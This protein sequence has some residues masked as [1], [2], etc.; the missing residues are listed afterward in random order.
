MIAITLGCDVFT[1]GIKGLG[2]SKIT[3]E[4]IK[5]KQK[6]FLQTETRGLNEIYKQRMV[7]AMK[8]DAKIVDT[9]VDAFLYEPGVL[10]TAAQSQ[11]E[12]KSSNAYIFD[13]PPSLPQY[14]SSFCFGEVKENDVEPEIC[15]CDGFSGGGGCPHIFL[16]F[17]G[18]HTCSKCDKSC[19]KPALLSQ[20]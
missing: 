18:S 1:E 9:L 4:I 11:N 7:T 16:K 6:V 3:D 15:K 2:P 20:K 10:D 17:K 13:P 5:M 12:V 8:V 19:C 14:L